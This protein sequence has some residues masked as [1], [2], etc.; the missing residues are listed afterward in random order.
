[1][2]AFV[3]VD[4]G[5]SGLRLRIVAGET[6]AEA[7][8][9]GFSYRSDSEDVDQFVT[10][11]AHAFDSCAVEASIA[12]GCV[13]L[14]G[15]PHD[16]TLRA[17]LRER[18][19]DLFDAPVLVTDD[20]MTSHAGALGG[21]GVVLSVGTG[22]VARALGAHG[23]WTRV[24]GWGAVLGDRGSAYDIG[25]R[26]LRAAVRG[27]EGI[28]PAT[29]LTEAMF[30]FLGGR[31]FS[32]VQDFYRSGNTFESIASFALTVGEAADAGDHIAL[33]VCKT[34][35]VDLMAT[36]RRSIELSGLG[37]SA[38][39]ATTGRLMLGP[40][41]TLLDHAMADAGIAVRPAAGTSLDGAIALARGDLPL[42]ES[43]LTDGGGQ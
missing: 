39:V 32:E 9:P 31:T 13:G 8:G 4:G 35:V 22:T 3:G 20:S 33:E 42:Y 21:P 25:L 29:A 28:G 19:E 12:R 14:T 7:I 43:I 5:K 41:G 2:T 30:G 17:A 6:V 40:V 18:L 36:V 27:F 11:I 26:G 16:P 1:M 15:V 37:A 38:V 34:A 24:D 10:A 23:E